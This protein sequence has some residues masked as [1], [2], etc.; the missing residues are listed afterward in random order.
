MCFPLRK[1]VFE[2]YVDELL[3]L[4]RNGIDPVKK[5]ACYFMAN[6]L[7]LY[8]NSERKHQIL[9]II[10]HDFGIT[11]VSSKRKTFIEFCSFA[12]PLMS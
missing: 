5:A 6:M 11:S 4:M 7:Y 2:L 12:M 9:S 10:V 3:D 8:Q 1:D